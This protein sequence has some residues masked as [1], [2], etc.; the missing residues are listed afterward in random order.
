M[1]TK[2]YI[3]LALLS[4]VFIFAA[5]CG[6]AG[7]PASTPEPLSSAGGA[8]L[9]TSTPI[10][11]ESP[12]SD[13]LQPPDPLYQAVRQL[14]TEEKVGQLLVVGITGT[15]PARDALWAIQEARVGGIVLFG[16]NISDAAQLLELTNG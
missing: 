16:R 2:R 11:A 8:V 5:S 10:P 1:M 9:P 15:S 3:S 14:S 4:F 13:P 12:D 7:D 6:P